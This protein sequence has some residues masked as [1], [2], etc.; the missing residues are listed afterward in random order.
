MGS[1]IRN[2]ELV[3]MHDNEWARYMLEVLYL[4]WFHVFC[5][6]L[7][8]YGAHAPNLIDF[9]RRLLNHIRQR[10]KPMRD[11]EFIYRRLFESCG[12][13]KQ[14]THLCELNK[15]MIKNNIQPDKVTSGTYFQALLQCKRRGGTKEADEDKRK[16]YF[17]H[18]MEDYQAKLNQP[19]HQ[20]SEDNRSQNRMSNVSL[21]H[22]KQSS[23]V[24]QDQKSVFGRKNSS[25]MHGAE[26]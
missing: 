17:A 19:I 1:L 23:L 15:E 10:I 25:Q 9:A 2:E 18:R 22:Q 13:C 21:N 7:P 5:S 26:P 11:I 3:K 16:S 6:T 24:S 4:L 8:I 12:T 20:D 14:I